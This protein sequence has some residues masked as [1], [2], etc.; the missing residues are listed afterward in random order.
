MSSYPRLTGIDILVDQIDD[1]QVEKIKELPSV[2][3]LSPF[4][5]QVGNL[6]LNEF[7]IKK[8]KEKNL[9]V[10]T[11]ESCTGGLVASS[12]TDVAGSSDV[13]IGSIVSYSNDIKMDHLEVSPLTLEKKG[14]SAMTW[15]SKWPLGSEKSLMST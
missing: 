7:V 14:P 2:K 15:L 9:T 13:F 11:A 6:E 3:L 5:W 10:A 1:N 12:L 4:I 8:L